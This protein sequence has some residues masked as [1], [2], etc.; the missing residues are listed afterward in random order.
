MVIFS[1]LSSSLN[2]D[3]I[4]LFYGKLN[5]TVSKCEYN[6]SKTILNI[7]ARTKI[8]MNHSIIC[9]YQL[10]SLWILLLDCFFKLFW[11]LQYVFVQLA[12]FYFSGCIL[13]FF[14][15]QEFPLKV[16]DIIKM[17][18]LVIN[19][20]FYASDGNVNSNPFQSIAW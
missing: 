4:N 17:T 1:W 8:R 11:I 7:D 9:R 12:L 6:S 16:L 10:K 15:R 3:V 18:S 14:K 19:A 5:W 2:Y 13:Y 20:L